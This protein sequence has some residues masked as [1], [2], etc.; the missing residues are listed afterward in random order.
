[1]LT[2]PFTF[3]KINGRLIRR[4]NRF[5]VEADIDGR[6][7]SAY[8]ANPGRL[9]ELLVPG[10]E[11]ILS[12]SLSKG[13]LPYTVL[14]CRKEGRDILLHTHLTNKIV[15]QLLDK[16]RL[17]SFENYRVIKEEPACGKHRFDFLLQH[18][19]T[20]N[21]YY[22]EI[23]TC[24]L[25]EGRVAMF[26]DATTKRGT[27][28]L[29]KLQE[30]SNSAIKTGCLFVIMNPQAEYFLPTYH[31]DQ[32]FAKAVLAVRHS[33]QLE[34]FAVG[35]NPGFTEVNSVKPVAIPYPFLESEL[36]DRGVYLLLVKMEQDKALTVG[37]LGK[38]EFKQG[39]YVYAG[40]ALNNL[41]K[42]TARHLR[43]KKQK[44]WHI[45]YLTAEADAVTAVPIVTGEN[46][47]CELAAGMQEMGSYPVKRF[48][49]SDC[50]C[51]GHLY[52]FAENPLHN[53]RFVELIQYYRLLR[54]EH[55]LSLQ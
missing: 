21:S 42:R 38:T 47:E 24:T 54:L 22:L 34:A 55:K 51:A 5:V 29:H 6:K 15:R 23:K 37:G 53:R 52:Y 45:D 1:M 39:Y 43:K 13:K 30:I 36:H 28:H 18:R 16:G 48:G 50:K 40:S 20:G 2:Y 11:L 14:A 44:R 41:S 31:I 8:L 10:T 9:W 19:Q 12:P 35:L 32:D 25:F 46:L 4:L 17:P 27:N 26:P 3:P 49:S 7:E 33:V